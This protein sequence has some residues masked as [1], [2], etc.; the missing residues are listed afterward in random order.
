MSRA[1]RTDGWCPPN[2]LTLVM[3]GARYNA[4]VAAGALA[5]ALGWQFVPVRSDI[6]VTTDGRLFPVTRQPASGRVL[7]WSSVARH[8]EQRYRDGD[9]WRAVV[10]VR[11]SALGGRS[12]GST[13]SR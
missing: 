11:P 13:R 7:A 4:G 3:V 5:Q 8:I 9:P 10:L 2:G 1:G 6:E 12:G